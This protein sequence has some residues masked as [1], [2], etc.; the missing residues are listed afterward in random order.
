MIKIAVKEILDFC[1]WSSIPWIRLIDSYILVKL[2]FCVK[3]MKNSFAF[4]PDDEQINVCQHLILDNLDFCVSIP[5]KT[6]GI[7]ASVNIST[8]W[9]AYMKS[10]SSAEEPYSWKTISILVLVSTSREMDDVTPS[11]DDALWKDLK[12]YVPCRGN[13][14][15]NINFVP[16]R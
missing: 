3:S 1:F 14:W 10:S 8:D 16:F 12:W 2:C 11:I 15:N 6:S 7:E 5:R 13:V 9:R 4:N